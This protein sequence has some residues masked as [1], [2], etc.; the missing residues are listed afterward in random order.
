MS[1]PSDSGPCNAIYGDV[2]LRK[3][4][5]RD[6]FIR[7]YV[8]RWW[9]CTLP[10]FRRFAFPLFTYHITINWLSSTV[11][12]GLDLL[13]FNLVHLPWP[14]LFFRT[15]S[16]TAENRVVIFNNP[17]L[18]PWPFKEVLS[19]RSQVGHE[20]GHFATY[21]VR[22]ETASGSISDDPSWRIHFW[23]YSMASIT[24]WTI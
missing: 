2:V 17:P 14:F 11:F 5:V 16:L 22:L 23:E 6:S 8:F 1:I 9:R 3:A 7:T 20:G 24:A 19:K 18:L 15:A 12:L 10:V 4:L 21:C 13:V